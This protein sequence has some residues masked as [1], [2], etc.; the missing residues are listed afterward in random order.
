[1]RFEKSARDLK[2]KISFAK[3]AQNPI[4]HAL[5][6][7]FHGWRH[8]SL[9]C[10]K[11]PNWEQKRRSEPLEKQWQL[12]KN[13]TWN[14]C[15]IPTQNQ[16]DFVLS[17]TL[18]SKEWLLKKKSTTF[19]KKSEN[20]NILKLKIIFR[21]ENFQIFFDLKILKNVIQILMK[22]KNFEIE[23]FRNF[24]LK[25][26]WKWKKKLKILT[27]KIIFNFKMFPFSDFFMKV[28]DFFFKSHSFSE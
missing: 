21:G 19:I 4:I 17:V 26:W 7:N 24:S 10:R 28:V 18:S 6:Y 27:S 1:M 11:S 23:N 12:Q 8:L 13:G 15:G 20:G 22:M 5:V 3:V 2:V 9:S 25:C 14:W 16:P